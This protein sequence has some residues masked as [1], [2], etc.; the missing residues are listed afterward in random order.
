MAQ[1]RTALELARRHGSQ[2]DVA[3]QALVWQAE[4]L[5]A[6][7]AGQADT[8]RAATA[9][10]IQREQ[11]EEAPDSVG[12]AR[13]TAADVERMLGN[14]PRER[15]HL[16]AARGLFEAKGN[17]VRARTMESRL[18]DPTVRGL[19]RRGISFLG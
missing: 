8:A 17:V 5:L 6:A 16:I 10:A 15:E 2:D 1:A 4:G 7:A 3:T 13:L 12:E 19:R 14:T 9:D 18:R 11:G